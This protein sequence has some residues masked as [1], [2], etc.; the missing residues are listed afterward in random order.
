[1][2]TV[3]FRIQHIFNSLPSDHYSYDSNESA[4]NDDDDDEHY[5]SDFFPSSDYDDCYPYDD[6]DM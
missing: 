5:I 4:N 1:M 3:F 2:S 6:W